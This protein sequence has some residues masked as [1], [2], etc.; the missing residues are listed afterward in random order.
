MIVLIEYNFSY[1]KKKF[2]III[3]W[4]D[5]FS[6]WSLKKQRYKLLIN[7]KWKIYS[8]EQQATVFCKSYSYIVIYSYIIIKISN[9]EKNCERR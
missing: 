2:M 8:I 3:C 5:E 4:I 9:V 7:K 1:L 6:F